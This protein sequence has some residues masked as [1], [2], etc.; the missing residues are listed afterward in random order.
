MK[1]WSKNR[2][3]TGLPNRYRLEITDLGDFLIHFSDSQ[4][5]QISKIDF[6]SL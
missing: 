4:V 3:K 6:F 2:L 1:N 5:C